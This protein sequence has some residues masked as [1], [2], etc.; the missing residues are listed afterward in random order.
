VSADRR[1][2]LDRQDHACRLDC[3]DGIVQVL[4]L[5]Q[6]RRV[7]ECAKKDLVRHGYGSTWDETVEVVGKVDVAWRSLLEIEMPDVTSGTNARM[8]S[9]EGIN[10]AK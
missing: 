10:D 3:Y 8:Y 4:D 5:V 7:D 2:L 6:R 1:Q 9:R